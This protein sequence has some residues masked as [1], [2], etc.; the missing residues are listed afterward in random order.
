MAQASAGP[1]ERET[2]DDQG[3]GLSGA[4]PPEG[5]ARQ[6]AN[7][8]ETRVRST[9]GVQGTAGRTRRGVER[10]AAPALR[11]Q[12]LRAAA[13]LPGDGR[14]R[15][16]R[17]DQARHVG[18]QSA[19][20]RGLQLQAAERRGAGS[21]TSSGARPAG[22]RSAAGSASSTA[23]T[24]RKC[25][26][27]ACIP[28]ILRSQR[29]P[30]S[31][32]RREAHLGERYARSWTSE[33]HLHRNGT[34]I[35]KFFLHLSKDEQRRRFLDRI[36]DPDKNW[37]FSHADMHEREYWK[38]YMKAYEAC[39]RATS[40]ATRRGTSFRPTTRKTPG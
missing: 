4:S 29:L 7:E 2:N 5:Q 34:R 36:D 37:K 32:A 23:P 13:D 40:T 8:G 12:P 18:R 16:G 24:T 27:C 20:L 28:E 9:G 19:G 35:V 31:A 21:T 26:S 3:E 10:A 15:Q 11:V 14:R 39:L 1:N 17:R 25:S 6:M 22:C 30:D 33:A 38:D